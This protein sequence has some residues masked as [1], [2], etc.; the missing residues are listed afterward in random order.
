MIPLSPSNYSLIRPSPRTP[1]SRCSRRHSAAI[2]ALSPA[3][4]AMS[5]SGPKRGWSSFAGSGRRS[6][7][8]PSLDWTTCMARDNVLVMAPQVVMQRARGFVCVNAHPEGC[9]RNVERQVA[10]VRGD[11]PVPVAGPKNVVV[12]GSSTGYGLASR[13]AAAW[14][15][16]A[17]TLG[18]FFERPPEDG[19]TA[20]AGYYNTV[21]FHNR[22]KKDGLYAASLNGDAFSDD[23][24]RQ[25]LEIIRKEFLPLDLVVYSL[26]SPRRVHPQTGHVHN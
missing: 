8:P 7:A 17:K 9:F 12:L 11:L 5:V 19:K 25:A 18:I 4:A 13:I 22:A 2:A 23:I 20:T 1:A 10:E 3:P 16:G 24:K 21:A 26:A 14:G 6:E 15:F